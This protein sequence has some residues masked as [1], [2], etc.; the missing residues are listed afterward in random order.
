VVDEGINDNDMEL[1]S[2][3]WQV[4]KNNIIDITNVT[5]N[6]LHV[7]KDRKIRLEKVSPAVIVKNMI[8]NYQ[9]KAEHLG[10]KIRYDVNDDLPDVSLDATS[11]RRMLNNLVVNAL[12][13]CAKDKT[14]DQHLVI[15]RAL[16]YNELQ[17]KFEVE[18][19]GPGIDEHKKQRMFDAFYSTKG[20]EGTGLGL[21][22]VNKIVKQHRGKIEVDT[23][24]GRGELHCIFNIA[25]VI[26]NRC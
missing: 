21:A 25:V 6:I 22:V 7:S 20:N 19:N 26:E 10:V 17:F 8:V 5:Q 15:V 16:R 14:T 1:I 23:K 2:R 3:G 13:A 18:D 9:S 12:S 24:P 11:I 4:V